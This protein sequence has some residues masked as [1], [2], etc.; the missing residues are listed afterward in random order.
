MNFASCRVCAPITLAILLLLL[1]QA[2]F[3]RD[4]QPAALPNLLRNASF[5]CGDGGYY[6]STNSRGKKILIPNDWIMTATG[7]IPIVSSA[8][9]NFANGC[10]QEA[11]VERIDGRDSVLIEALDLEKPPEPGKPFDVSLIQQASATSGTAYSLSGWTLSLCGGSSVPSDCPNDH[12]IAK[13]LG[14]DPTGGMDPSAPTGVWTENRR[15]FWTAE[16]GRN[17]WTQLSASAIAQAMTVTVFARLDSPFQWHGNHGFIDAL[18]LLQ[19]PTATLSVVT[20]TTS[21]LTM[22]LQWNGS[23]GPDI[24]TIPNGAYQARFDVQY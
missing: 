2:A 12:Y 10:D 9:I 1:A 23:L 19:A 6:E 22:T 20:A 7:D 14:I 13:L 21:A 5:E 4:S 8:R 3:A 17:G 15:N 24:P 18:S 16:S 11:H